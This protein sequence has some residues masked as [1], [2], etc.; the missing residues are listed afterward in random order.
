MVSVLAVAAG[1]EASDAAAGG[2]RGGGGRS[3]HGDRG[4]E[5]RRGA[6]PR[7]G[8]AAGLHDVIGRRRPTRGTV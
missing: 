5:E 3:G 2:E 4:G 7:R 6:R 1:C 8:P